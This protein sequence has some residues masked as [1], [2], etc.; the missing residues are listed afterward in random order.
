VLASPRFASW[1]EDEVFLRHLLSLTAAHHPTHTLQ[2]PKELSVLCAVVD[3]VAGG[4]TGEGLSVLQAHSRENLLPQLWDRARSTTRRGSP[5]MRSELV[6]S[7]PRVGEAAL[8]TVGKEGPRT[9][10]AIPTANT[11]F[12]NGRAST[13]FALRW[14]GGE[15][16]EDMAVV[17][18]VDVERQVVRV[19]RWPGRGTTMHLPLVPIT[20]L[21]EVNAGLGNIV[22]E[23]ECDEGSVPASKELEEVIPRLLAAREAR[24]LEE[25]RGGLSV[26]ALVM[27]R[28]MNYEADTDLELLRNPEAVLAADFGKPEV[29][30]DLNWLLEQGG[31]L[32]RVMSGGGGWGAKQGLLCLDPER[33]LSQTDEEDVESFERDLLNELF[34]G[35]RGGGRG[36]SVV[37]KGN[38][39]MFFVD[40]DTYPHRPVAP[41]LHVETGF[42][43]QVRPHAAGGGN[44]EVFQDD[45]M[46]P[47]FGAVSATAM[48]IAPESQRG[49]AEQSMKIDVPCSEYKTTLRLR[50]DGVK[51][52]N[53]MSIQSGE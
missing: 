45:R 46:M 5:D 16:W 30:V 19:P 32:H 6:F 21:R 42:L 12:V 9:L 37:G 36:A 20:V 47:V 38:R 43:V 4:D 35:R 48:F 3:G 34:P 26:W 49:R 23:I 50:G 44:N 11:V 10:V 22:R 2:P 8:G 24:G 17:E 7:A 51:V 40:R 27:P 25:L 52:D 18:R 15:R 39:V 53:A 1:L 28:E 14:R 31:R 41:P 29:E 13:M 33:S